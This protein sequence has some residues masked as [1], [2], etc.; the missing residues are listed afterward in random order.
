M[1]TR[2]NDC[3]FVDPDWGNKSTP[4]GGSGTHMTV[5]LGPE[6]YYT[7]NYGS[8]TGAT[9]ISRCMGPL[10]AKDF[11]LHIG[12]SRRKPAVSKGIQKG[13]KTPPPKPA[14]K[15]KGLWV[16]GHLLNDN[17]GGSGTYNLNLTPLTQTANKQHAGYEGRIK[18]M[19]EIADTL[20]RARSLTYTIGVYYEVMVVGQFG[21]FSPYDLA[22]SHIEIS[23]WPVK[24]DNTTNNITP[25]TVSDIGKLSPDAQR[26]LNRSF[27]NIQIH[28][29]DAHLRTC[30]NPNC[31]HP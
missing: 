31:N 16:A 17:L 23:A 18:A 29:D 25:L 30:D 2:N 11:T 1:P 4:R 6:A 22:P 5:Y 13:P 14:L 15:H 19:L 26:V 27:R 9:S 20:R 24:A 7:V 12:A 3:Y 21:N 10:N 28:N 8:P